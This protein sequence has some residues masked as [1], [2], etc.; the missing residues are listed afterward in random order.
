MTACGYAPRALEDRVRPRHLG[1][2]SGPLNFTV[3]GHVSLR[4]A[5][6]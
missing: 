6:E 3:R 4:L 1:G 5:Q 2:A